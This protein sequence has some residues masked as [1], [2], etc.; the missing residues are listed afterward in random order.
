[1]K[2][3]KN[4]GEKKLSSKTQNRPFIEIEAESAFEENQRRIPIYFFLIFGDC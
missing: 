2:M 4:F 3:L 1:M